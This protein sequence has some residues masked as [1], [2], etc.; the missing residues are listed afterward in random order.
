MRDTTLNKWKFSAVLD[1]ITLKDRD[2]EL[3]HVRKTT[4][5]RSLKLSSDKHKV[6]K[7][8]LNMNHNKFGAEEEPLLFYKLYQNVIVF[9]S[10]LYIRVHIDMEKPSGQGKSVNS[11]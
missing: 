2:I 4:F 8:A 11:V 3:S 10:L 7:I 1:S 9:G 6:S 5:K